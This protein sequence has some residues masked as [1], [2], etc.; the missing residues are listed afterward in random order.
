MINYHSDPQ[1]MLYH[2]EVEYIYATSDKVL[3]Y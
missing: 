1:N 3:M 2:V